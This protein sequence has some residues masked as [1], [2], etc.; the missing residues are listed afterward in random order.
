MNIATACAAN[1][2][3]AQHTYV[4]G[5][6]TPC[7]SHDSGYQSTRM[8]RLKHQA[9]LLQGK[10]HDAEPL[11]TVSCSLEVNSAPLASHGHQ[12]K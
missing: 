3:S 10:R 12:Y 2:S 5:V 11:Q 1:K 6:V 7:V 8:L 9:C 4:A